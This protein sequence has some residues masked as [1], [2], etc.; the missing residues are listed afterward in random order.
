MSDAHH[1]VSAPPQTKKRMLL[2]VF[3]H[4]TNT[5]PKDYLGWLQASRAQGFHTI[6]LSYASSPFPD[7]A[8]SDFC[9]CSSLSPLQC[10]SD[11]HHTAFFGGTAMPWTSDSSDSIVA[12]LDELLAYLHL[13]YPTESWASFRWSG[14]VTWS[15]SM[16]SGHEQGGSHVAYGLKVK[17]IFRAALLSSPQDIFFDGKSSENVSMATPW[18]D[19]YGFLHLSEIH[20]DVILRN[21][22]LMAQHGLSEALATVHPD[23]SGGVLH[24]SKDPA[25]A[26][27]GDRM[28][29]ARH[30]TSVRSSCN[31]IFFPFQCSTA[32]DGCDLCGN[33]V[34][35]SRSSFW[36]R[37]LSNEALSGIEQP[38]KQKDKGG[39]SSS[40]ITPLIVFVISVCVII[41]GVIFVCVVWQSFKIG[42]KEFVQFDEDSITKDASGQNLGPADVAQD[43]ASEV[44]GKGQV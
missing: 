18:Q 38:L 29:A 9:N 42:R 21:W 41:L 33:G 4:A 3:L 34:C 19:V 15:S 43:T 5:A 6:G 8:V 16:W 26:Q 37:L 20:S 14:E 13:R 2:H 23:L 12:R 25:S 30:G 11:Y 35:R 28:F 40:N 32:R 27:L 1:V 10:L 7:V 24:V 31:C 39:K 36:H 44:V 22:R 17:R